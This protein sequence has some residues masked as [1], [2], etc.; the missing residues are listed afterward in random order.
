MPRCASIL[1]LPV[2]AAIT[3]TD[4]GGPVRQD[5]QTILKQGRGTPQGRAAWDRLSDGGPEVLPALLEGL[6][7]PDTAAANW[8]RTAFDRVLD[9]A[10][11]KAGKGIDV[12]RL[13]AFGKDPKHA[14]RARRLALDAV[15]RL[16]PGTARELYRGWLEDPEFRF[17]A[18][19]LALEAAS[20]L[21]KRGE[22]GPAIA[23]Y[24]K[25][26]A[27]SRDIPQG[28]AAAAGLLDLGVPVSVAEHLGFLMDWY[29]IGPFDAHGMKGFT[30][31][32]PP[33]KQ[34]DLKAKYAGQDGRPL[35]WVRYRVREP[36]PRGSARHIA[37]VNLRERD[38]LGDADDAVAF[39][40]TEVI[41][42]AARAVEF[43][44]AADDNFTIWVNGKRA[45]GFE[46]YRNGVRFDRHRFRV[47][48]HAGRNTVLV[49][50]IQ[51]PANAEPNWEFLLRVVDDTGKGVGLKSGLPAVP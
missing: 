25:A 10:L 46:E 3:F 43:R 13:L 4:A 6:N 2:V 42:P 35:R 28:R 12:E 32:Y 14:G 51:S 15:E 26:L 5:I 29:L 44:G 7:I 38:A 1:V 24:R 19:A 30:T 40:Y 23:A 22:K 27:A 45:F 18:V 20:D 17:E 16:R 31:T 9:R 48:L 8:L 34:V 21:S 41:A 33:E 49:K 39:A 11:A 36:G 47:R 37:L 50:V